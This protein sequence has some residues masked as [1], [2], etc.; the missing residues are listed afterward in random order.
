MRMRRVAW[1][2]RGILL[3]VLAIGMILMISPT[4]YAR[5]R[6]VTHVVFLNQ[7]VEIPGLASIPAK[8]PCQN[9]AWA[10]ALESILKAQAVELRQSYWIMKSAGGELCKDDDTD[11]EALTKIIT[12]EYIMSDGHKV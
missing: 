10:A 11:L 2:P 9:W 1:R 5:K 7:T 4:T 6:G 8:Q 12:G 3:A